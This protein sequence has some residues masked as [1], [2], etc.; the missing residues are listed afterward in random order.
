MTYEIEVVRRSVYNSETFSGD[1]CGIGGRYPNP[2]GTGIE[3]EK[4]NKRRRRRPT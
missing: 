4:G 3:D 2:A 1:F